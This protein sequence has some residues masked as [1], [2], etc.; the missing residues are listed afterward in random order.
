MR[1]LWS[2]K[3]MRCFRFR[4]A[5]LFLLTTLVCL[6]L[7]AWPSFY[8]WYSSIPVSRAVAISNLTSNTNLF[9]PTKEPLSESEVIE[10]IESE[11]QRFSLRAYEKERLER[12]LR[13]GLLPRGS[14]I[15]ASFVLAR[16]SQGSSVAL[17][18]LASGGY[19]DVAIRNGPMLGADESM[20][21]V[22]PL[23]RAMQNHD[24]TLW[25]W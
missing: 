19:Q 2:A 14:E 15:T 17:I 18:M 13:S 1:A 11:C 7:W 12:V 6:S 23:N 8:E 9:A 4:L 22:D 24:T 20:L 10:A 3:C 25:A 16:G 21:E 5:T